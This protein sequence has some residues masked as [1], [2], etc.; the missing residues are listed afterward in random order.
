MNFQEFLDSRNGRAVDVDGNWGPQCWD[1]WSDYAMTLFGCS[2]WATST[3]SGGSYHH[4]GYTCEIWHN[5]SGGPLGNW[6]TPVG[7]DQPAQYGDVVIW[8]WGS[9]VGPNSHIAL[10]VS[11]QGGSLYCLTQNPG[12]SHYANLSKAGVLGYLRPD[13][14]AI[15][16]G[17][18]SPA[19]PSTPVTAGSTYTVVAGD[20][21]S[22][23]GDRCGVAWQDI[24]NANRDKISNPNM[25]YVGQVLTIPG[26]SSSAPA[27]APS[28]GGQQY[29][30]VSGDTLWG[31]AERFYGDGS[32]WP[33]IYNASSLSSGNPNLI[34]PGEIVNIP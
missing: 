21:L 11:D 19:A 25:I 3:N 15:I 2:M 1:L 8:E 12:A 34:Y 28:G 9:A 17:G 31:I 7:A 27:P 5:F 29:T 22:G 14:Q 10:V 16:G 26:G 18:G 32:R 30:I 4:P 24:Y 13:N 6:F 33:E 23:I 20:T